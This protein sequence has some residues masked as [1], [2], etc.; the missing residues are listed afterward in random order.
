MVFQN[1]SAQGG[2]G[3]TAPS[4]YSGSVPL[5]GS[6]RFYRLRSASP[7][8]VAITGIRIVGANAVIQYQ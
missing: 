3:G 6:A 1:N 7:P 8:A 4:N 2:R 5:N